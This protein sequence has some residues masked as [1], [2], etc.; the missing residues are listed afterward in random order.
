MRKLF[1]WIPTTWTSNHAL[2][3][4][5]NPLFCTCTTL[6]RIWLSFTVDCWSYDNIITTEY[7]NASET[8]KRSW[9]TFLLH[10]S[11]RASKALKTPGTLCFSHHPV[12]HSRE[13]GNDLDCNIIIKTKYS[14]SSV[15]CQQTAPSSRAPGYAPTAPAPSFQCKLGMT[16]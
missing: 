6:S 15:L 9:Q 13:S 3:T 8:S 12:S 4:T 7:N 14:V 2:N 11:R 1:A 5:D 16:Y 10:L